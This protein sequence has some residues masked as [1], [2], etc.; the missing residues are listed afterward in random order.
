V[1]LPNGEHAFVD[2]TKLRDHVLNPRH[3]RG[4]HKA[5]V[6]ASVL[7][8]LQSDA[9]L[10]RNELLQAALRQEALQAEN[11]AYGQR[12]I[13]D[14]ECTKGERAAMVRSGWIILTNEDFPRLTT[15]FVL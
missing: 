7:Q 8:I 15:C 5:R 13:V 12:Y 2:L 1:Q 9:Q 6:F 14:F 11:D 4:R 3:P 10:L